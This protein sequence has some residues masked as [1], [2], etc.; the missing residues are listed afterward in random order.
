VQEIERR[1]KGEGLA[2]SGQRLVILSGAIMGQRGGTN[3]MKL[4]EVA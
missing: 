2:K 3:V 4:H 1:L